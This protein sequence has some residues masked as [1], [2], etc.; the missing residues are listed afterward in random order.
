MA[1]ELS[2]NSLL[3]Y[4]KN[5]V[6]VQ[7]TINSLLVTVTGNGFNSLA[8]FT[9]TTAAIA[10]PLGGSA[11]PGGWLFIR[12]LDPTNYIQVLTATGGTVFARLLPG[13][14]CLFRLDATVTAPAVKANVASCSITF[15]IFDT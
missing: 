3:T 5:N 13:E 8:A 15:C 11:I 4:T 9:A 14:F 10:I 6:T 1:N 7:E 2:L 12:N